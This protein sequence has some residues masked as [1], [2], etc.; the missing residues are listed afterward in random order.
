MVHDVPGNGELNTN[1]LFSVHKFTT[2]SYSEH[3]SLHQVG[4][5]EAEASGDRKC[6]MNLFAS[7]VTYSIQHLRSVCTDLIR[8]TFKAKF[9]VCAR[10]GLSRFFSLLYSSTIL[11]VCITATL[12]TLVKDKHTHLSIR[13]T[14]STVCDSLTFGGIFSS[15]SCFC[16][17]N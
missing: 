2:R 1:L 7:Q 10:T 5:C 11:C 9:D 17:I 14:F 16:V 13:S 15:S 8:E 3:Q 6:R 4:Q 12:C